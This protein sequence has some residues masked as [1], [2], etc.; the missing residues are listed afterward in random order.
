[1]NGE[2]LE[3]EKRVTYKTQIDTTQRQTQIIRTDPER[4]DVAI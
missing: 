3:C 2:E 1:M 4:Y